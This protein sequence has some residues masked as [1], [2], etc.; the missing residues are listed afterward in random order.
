MTDHLGYEAHDRAGGGSGN[1]RNG[2]GAKTVVGKSGPLEIE[3][4]RD[5][6]GDFESRLVKKWQQRVM[7]IDEKWTYPGP[8]DTS[9]L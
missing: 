5:R 2:T 9:G 4:P 1:S 3:T 6:N 8:Y 7:V